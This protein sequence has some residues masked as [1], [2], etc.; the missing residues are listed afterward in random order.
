MTFA[1]TLLALVI[2]APPAAPPSL[3]DVRREPDPKRRFER[4]ISLADAQ[5]QAARQIVRDH[6]LRADLEKA[7]A[8]TGD[9]AQFALDSLRSTGRR[10][11]KLSRQYKK[12][13]VRTRELERFLND[14]A[15]ALSVEDRP[16]AEKAREQVGIV[17]EE[18]LLG[19]MS[20]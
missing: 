3:D 9:A 8:T 1:C 13:E 15:L 19:V 5:A 20:K 10:P 12:G 17:H 2:A 4:A 16:L 14:L 6:G 18:F 11:S 7:L